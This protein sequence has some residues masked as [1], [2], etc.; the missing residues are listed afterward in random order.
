[1]RS[2]PAAGWYPAT[3]LRWDADANWNHAN[4][5]ENPWDIRPFAVDPSDVAFLATG[6]RGFEGRHRRMPLLNLYLACRQEK[7]SDTPGDCNTPERVVK[8]E[9]LYDG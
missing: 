9:R 2:H 6:D 4:A 5:W 3:Q 7:H 1:M 8:Y